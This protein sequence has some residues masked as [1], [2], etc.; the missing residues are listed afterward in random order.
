MS[1][2]DNFFARFGT[3][4]H[5]EAAM[6]SGDRHI[7]ANAASNISASP[8]QIDTFLNHKHIITRT[9]A[10]ENPAISTKSLNNLIKQND[11]YDMESVIKNPKLNSKQISTILKNT[12]NKY[13]LPDLLK[14]KNITADHIKYIFDNH[15]DFPHEVKSIAIQH[16]LADRDILS[17]VLKNPEMLH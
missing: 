2:R 11:N 9:N 6:E 17:H 7:V 12:T 4:K 5:V 8:D 15:Q 1:N 10:I 14:H 3:K 16:E 13:M